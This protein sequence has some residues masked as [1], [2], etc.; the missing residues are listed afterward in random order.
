MSRAAREDDASYGELNFGQAAGLI[1]AVERCSELVP[2]LSREAED[3]LAAAL[4]PRPA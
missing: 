3:L 1:D 2:R 4:S